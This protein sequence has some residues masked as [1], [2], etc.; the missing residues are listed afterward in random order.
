MRCFHTTNDKHPYEL[1]VN[2]VPQVA[3]DKGSLMNHLRSINNKYTSAQDKVKVEEIY[4]KDL[5]KGE[6]MFLGI[7]SLLERNKRALS[8]LNSSQGIVNNKRV[9]CSKAEEI[10]K[11]LSPEHDILKKSISQSTQYFTQL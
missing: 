9:V 11:D 4:E 10:I 5:L 7:R 3:I 8:L 2:T 1:E 6:K